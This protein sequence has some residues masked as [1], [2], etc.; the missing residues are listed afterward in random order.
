MS[1]SIGILGNSLAVYWTLPFYSVP[2]GASVQ[3][4]EWA[5]L[6]CSLAIWTLI[7][8]MPSGLRCFKTSGKRVGAVGMALSVL[9][10][11]LSMLILQAAA[12]FCV[13]KMGM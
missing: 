6:T 2:S 12:F 8:G 5:I 1:L 10:L 9:P 13:F 4:K 7:F 11:P 3:P